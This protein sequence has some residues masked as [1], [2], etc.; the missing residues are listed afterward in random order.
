MKLRKWVKVVL[1]IVLVVYFGIGFI[2]LFTT[3]EDHGYY[4]CN[5]KLIKACHGDRYE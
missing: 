4:T 3:H 2:Q 1:L 5:G